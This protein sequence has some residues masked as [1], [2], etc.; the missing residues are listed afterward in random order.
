MVILDE[1]TYL[2][3]LWMIQLQIT[4][5]WTWRS[6]SMSSTYNFGAV[7]AHQEHLANGPASTS[8]CQLMM[9]HRCRHSTEPQHAE[10][11]I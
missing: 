4:W 7:P 3:C 1:T 8:S 10:S 9:Q 6:G 11:R 2:R 5:E